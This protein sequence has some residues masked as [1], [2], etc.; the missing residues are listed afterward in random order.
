M[1]TDDTAFHN[2]K[3]Y[4]AQAKHKYQRMKYR[5]KFNNIK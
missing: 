5:I 4:V 2:I 1:K 3:L